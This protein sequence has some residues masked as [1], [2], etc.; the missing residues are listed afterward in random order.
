MSNL[1]MFSV[2]FDFAYPFRT[3]VAVLWVNLWFH[4]TPALNFKSARVQR[5]MHDG[6]VSRSTD[7]GFKF[8]GTYKYMR[9]V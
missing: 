7:T 2:C 5:V 8:A 6:A 4:S 9:G 1:E 3:P